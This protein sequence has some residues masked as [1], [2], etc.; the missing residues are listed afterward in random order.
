V[1]VFDALAGRGANTGGDGLHGS[2]AAV[3]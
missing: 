3:R 2:A 1:P